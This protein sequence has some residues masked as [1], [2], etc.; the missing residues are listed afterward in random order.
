VQQI[1]SV[2]WFPVD[3]W[4]AA[5]ERWPEL[6][7]EMPRDHL[8]YRAAIEHRLRVVS[9]QTVGARLVATPLTVEA[10]LD[11]EA[12]AAEAGESEVP[13]SQIRGRA[14]S[15]RAQ[16]GFGTAWPPERNAACW[17]GSGRKYKQCCAALPAPP[18]SG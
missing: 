13:G 14:A 2:G 7:D 15:L 17:C 18:A 3:E 1:L 5:L 6:A 11:Q 9:P 16:Q 12:L 10:V 4:A 8:A